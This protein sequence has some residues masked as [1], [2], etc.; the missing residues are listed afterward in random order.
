MNKG[1]WLSMVLTSAL[2]LSSVMTAAAFTV[3][4][5]K[6]PRDTKPA[7]L[8]VVDK[9]WLSAEPVAINSITKVNVLVN[10]VTGKVEYVWSYQYNR[11]VRPKLSM[12]DIQN[13]YD[14]SR[15]KGR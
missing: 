1:I 4:R 13:L 15:S 2:T 14:F 10:R 12:P 5:A 7:E 9:V 3:T 6:T 11:Y 8:S